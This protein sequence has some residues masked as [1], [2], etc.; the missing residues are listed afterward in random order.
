MIFKAMSTFSLIL[1]S[2][3]SFA[4]D[5]CAVVA[6]S[7]THRP[8]EYASLGEIEIGVS[9]PTMENGPEGTLTLCTLGYEPGECATPSHLA[10]EWNQKEDSGK[11]EGEYETGYVL[12]YSVETTSTPGVYHFSMHEHLEGYGG[13]WIRTTD[14]SAIFSCP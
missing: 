1:V 9:L 4:A 13:D 11:V 12:S 8:H 10:F 3:G 6:K 14:H 7:V 5:P 2:F